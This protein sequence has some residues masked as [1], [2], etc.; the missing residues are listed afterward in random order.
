MQSD[1]DLQKEIE[2]IQDHTFRPEVNAN[3]KKI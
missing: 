2:Y 1:Y 3:S